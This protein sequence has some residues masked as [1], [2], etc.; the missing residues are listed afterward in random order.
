MLGTMGANRGTVYI[1]DDDPSVQRAL[2]RLARSAGLTSRVFGTGAEFLAATHG[3][4][5]AC[6]VLDLRLPDMH[7]L[8]VQRKLAHTD[9]D[10]RVIVL[11][12]YGDELT[13]RE[14]L[15]GHAVAFLSKPVD[16]QVLLDAIR[17]AFA[18]SCGASP[19][20]SG[21]RGDA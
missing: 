7:G 11:T 2:Q 17:W 4:R 1:V 16:E 9:P 19:P 10:V 13:R 15:L 6:V 20:P 21:N 5:P 14:A 18:E 3:P 12:G 8:E